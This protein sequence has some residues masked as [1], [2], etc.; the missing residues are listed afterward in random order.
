MIETLEYIDLYFTNQLSAQ[1]KVAFE[2]RCESDPAFA[3]EVAFYISAR[4]ELKNVLIEQKKSEF[5]ELYAGLSAR[6]PSTGIIKRLYPLIA[7]AAA[8]L[9]LFIGWQ[10]FFNNRPAD[11]P[12]RIA[13]DYIEKNIRTSGVTMGGSNKDSLETGVAEFNKKNYE[14]AG[15]IFLSLSSPENRNAEAIKYLGFVYLVNKDYDKAISQFDTLAQQT[16]L[17]ANPGLF[18]KALVLMKRSGK[19]DISGAKL[20]LK[21]V[22]EKNLP[23]NKEAKEWLDKM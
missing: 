12:A 3:N 16:D 14:R 20:I 21:E 18:Y 7:A 10:V 8:C 5:Q 2:K 1:E 11:A 15:K 19:G 23:G 6:K 22:I 9:I 4:S 17:Y 13:A